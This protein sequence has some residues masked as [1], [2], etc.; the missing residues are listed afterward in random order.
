MGF[1]I[2]RN[3]Y[4]RDGWNVIDFVVV[5][6]AILEFFTMFSS[7]KALKG[8]RVMRAFRPLMSINQIPSMKKLVKILFRSLPNLA[9]VVALLIFIIFLFAIIGLHQF[10]GKSYYRCRTTEEPLRDENNNLYWPLLENYDILCYSNLN[11]NTCP[12]GSY[13]GHPFQYGISLKDDHVESTEFIGY[14]IA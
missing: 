10:S 7:L 4:L 8:I 13:C 6:S 2:K 5:I 1:F 3:S 11:V 9:N 12:K 14:G